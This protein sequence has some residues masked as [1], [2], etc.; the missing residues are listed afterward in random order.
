MF[1]LTALGFLASNLWV[2]E[3]AS[4]VRFQLTAVAL[5]GMVVGALRGNPVATV[6]AFAAII[7]NVVVVG[8]HLRGEAGVPSTTDRLRIGHVNLQERD[9]DEGALRVAL[10][11]RMP[12]VFFV[13]EP[14]AGWAKTHRTFAGYRVVTD[15]SPKVSALALVRSDVRAGRPRVDGLP[16]G[17][18]AVE[19][20]FAG[21]PTWILA[22]H[23][24]SPL[25][26]RFLGKRD[27]ALDAA[28]RLAA[29]R[30]GRRIVLG[31]F[32]AV[33]WSPVVAR[34]VRESGLASSAT[35]SGLQASWP[36]FL[37]R[38]GVAIDQLFHSHDLVVAERSLGP[39][40][41]S[42]H[43]SLWIELAPGGS[44]R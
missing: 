23:A 33:P 34:F 44:A 17:A 4:S 39:S 15:G 19:T 42:T 13:L 3:L 25:T 8:P 9:L 27:R 35:A 12:D 5:V 6:L 11:A 24:H 40:L 43:R 22:L 7:G 21:V 20:M 36:W 30:N 10:R 41:G 18:L 37:W 28:A 38:L 31:D 16:G 14:P 1:A 26:P 29:S 2:A 32:N